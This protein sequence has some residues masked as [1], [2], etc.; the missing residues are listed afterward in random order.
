MLLNV[1]MYTWV[2]L[3]DNNLKRI[4]HIDAVCANF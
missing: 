1:F 4:S 2:L 3:D